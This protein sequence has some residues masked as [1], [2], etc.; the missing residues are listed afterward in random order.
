M[1]EEKFE[2][3]LL[4]LIASELYFLLDIQAAREMYGKS[5]FSLG[6]AEKAA[7]DQIVFQTVGAYYRDITPE[8]L[9]EQTGK[10]G[11]A[12]GFQTPI[13]RQDQNHKSEP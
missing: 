8:M 4:K 5:Y 9:R 1:P 6:L 2:T 11:S 3:N 13:Q 7:V 12:V 10:V